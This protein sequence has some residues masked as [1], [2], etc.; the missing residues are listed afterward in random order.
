[1]ATKIYIRGEFLDVYPYMD[2]LFL[3]SQEGDLLLAKTEDLIADESLHDFMFR[4][5]KMLPGNFE[6]PKSEIELTLAK[7]SKLAKLPDKFSFSDLRFF[8]A[9]II[10]GSTEGLKFLSFNTETCQIAV[11]KKITDAPINSI[12]AKYMTVFASSLEAGVTTLFGVSAGKFS[13][14]TQGGPETSRVGVSDSNIYYYLGRSDVQY[15]HYIRSKPSIEGF[16]LRDED[17]KEEIS[18]IYEANPYSLA[19]LEPDFVFNANN[20]VYFKVKKQLF[21]LKDGN[22]Q[23]YEFPLDIESKLI[24]AH[25]FAGKKCFEFM[26]GLYLSERNNIFTLL[27]GE[28]ITSRGYSNSV[29]YKN[30]VSAVND[31]GAFLFRI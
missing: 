2:W 22:P 25:L 9:N 8:Y 27:D 21:Y 16:T 14:T 3:L 7:F 28:C 23:M 19:N 29:N 20:G 12:S 5:H 18:K 10:C 30:T 15:S 17:D 26:N 4:Q 1:M 13:K 6:E 31:D 11:D 24:R